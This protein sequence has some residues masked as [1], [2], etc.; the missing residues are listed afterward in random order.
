MFE[1]SANNVHA[2]CFS[3]CDSSTLYATADLANPFPI[4]LSI[5]AFAALIVNCLCTLILMKFQDYSGSL[6]KA[7][8]LSARNDAL[9]NI[10]IIA[11]GI[12][13]LL[14]PSIWPD[15][16]VGLF[17]AYIRTESA[18]EIYI[19]ARKELKNV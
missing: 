11:T 14:Y 1:L 19:K 17:I 2:N 13:T 5:V 3:Y 18:I 15:I 10:A 16:L 4:E 12:I 6:T 8:F 9:A 7:A